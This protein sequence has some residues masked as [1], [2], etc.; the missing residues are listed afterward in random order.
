[1][2]AVS[3]IRSM[4]PAIIVSMLPKS[5]GSIARVGD[6]KYAP[7]NVRRATIVRESATLGQVAVYAAAIDRGFKALKNH[8]QQM[9]K[10]GEQNL[11]TSAIQKLEK[12]EPLFLAGLAFTANISAEMISRKV[13]PRNVWKRPDDKFSAAKASIPATLIDESHGKQIPVEIEICEVTPTRRS[14]SAS[15]T[16]PIQ[17]QPLPF[18]SRQ[19]APSPVVNPFQYKPV[20]SP[21]TR[22]NFS[23]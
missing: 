16:Q 22:P 5:A 17:H 4:A 15:R 14:K 12:N 3:T 21:V 11:L 20:T 1:M 18:A 23:V 7:R 6:D 10:A 19:S 13:A 8:A 2:G 9:A